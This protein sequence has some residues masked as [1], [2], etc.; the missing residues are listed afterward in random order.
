VKIDN[1]FA[2][3]KRRNVTK[4]R[5]RSRQCF[6]AKDRRDAESRSQAVI[7]VCAGASPGVLQSAVPLPHLGGVSHR[8]LAVGGSTA[9]FPPLRSDET[10]TTEADDGMII[11]D[12]D[13]R[14]ASPCHALH[15]NTDLPCEGLSESLK[16]SSDRWLIGKVALIPLHIFHCP[17]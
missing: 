12:D 6:R 10:G 3:L 1:F 7:T 2:E 15:G 17:P 9:N 5:S 4:S 13:T 14:E 8:F 16:K 11:G